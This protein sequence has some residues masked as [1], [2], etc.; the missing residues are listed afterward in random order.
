[1]K[2]ELDL[3]MKIKESV[4]LGKNMILIYNK[5]ANC[6]NILNAN[7]PN[8]NSLR[9]SF[10]NKDVG[11]ESNGI[12]FSEFTGDREELLLRI[13]QYVESWEE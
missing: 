5:Y 8:K 12:R 13:N 2:K 1:M 6:L 3:R 4:A 9:L 10:S 11:F 7:T